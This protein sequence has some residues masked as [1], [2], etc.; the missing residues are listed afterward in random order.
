VAPLHQKLIHGLACLVAIDLAIAGVVI[1][2]RSGSASASSSASAPK[3]AATSNG[4]IAQSGAV[5]GI[6][7]AGQFRHRRNSGG[8][9]TV[10]TGA[11][12]SSEVAAGLPAG[13]SSSVTTGPASTGHH[14]RPVRPVDADQRAVRPGRR[15]RRSRG[16]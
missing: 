15:H 13:T 11:G 3:T 4:S 1:D 16:R 9:G 6:L 10:T 7:G 5:G 8:G 14:Q 2:A 12:S